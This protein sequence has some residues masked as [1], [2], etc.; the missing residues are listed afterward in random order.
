[1]LAASFIAGAIAVRGWDG[2]RGQYRS[3][4]PMDLNFIRGEIQQLRRQ[5]L[6]GVFKQAPQHRREKRQNP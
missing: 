4:W 5:V 3:P 2:K 1:M 6:R